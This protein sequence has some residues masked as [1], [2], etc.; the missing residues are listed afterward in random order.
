VDIA[1]YLQ[2]LHDHTGRDSYINYSP[3]PTRDKAGTVDMRGYLEW[4]GHNRYGI[5]MTVN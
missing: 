2:W 4:L 5:T 1:D 3:N